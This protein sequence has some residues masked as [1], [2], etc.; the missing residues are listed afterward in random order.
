[1]FKHNETTVDD[2]WKLA[3]RIGID[4]FS[5]ACSWLP[6]K[7]HETGIEASSDKSLRMLNRLKESFKKERTC[8]W[9]YGAVVHNPNGSVSP[10][11]GV[12]W[13]EDDFCTWPSGKNIHSV[14]NDPTMSWHENW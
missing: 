10:C 11:C 13:E 12:S 1:V 7:H 2:A 8:S 3:E 9:L 6:P 4:R 14:M 5:V